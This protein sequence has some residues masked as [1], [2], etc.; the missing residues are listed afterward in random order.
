MKLIKSIIFALLLISVG[1]DVDYFDNPNQPTTPPSAAVFNNAMH[2]LITNTR[3]T[4][5]LGRFTQATMQYW[6]QSEY[7]DEDRYGYRESMRQTW[8]TFYYNLER[9]RIVIELN[10]DAATKDAMMA[11]GAN[12]NQ[13]ACARIM[14]AYTFNLMADTWGDIPYYSYGSPSANF[15]ALQLKDDVLNPRYATQAEIYADILNELQ[16]AADQLDSNLPGFTQGDVVYNGDVEKWRLFANSLRLR[17]AVK[18][19]SANAALATTHINDAIADGVFTSNDDNA[20]FTYDS[21]DKNA[22]PMYRAWNV[23]NR[24]DFAVSNTLVTLL[25]G[26]NIR[27]TPT[28]TDLTTNPFFGLYDPRLE[29]YA[30]RN[31]DGEYVGMPIAE[32]SAIAATITYESLPN[33]DNIIDKP[34]YAPVLMEYAEV[35]FLLSELNSWDQTNYTNGIRASMEKWG[36]PTADINAYIAAVPAANEENVLTQ[37]YIALYMDG[38]TAWAEYRR[39]GYPNILIKPGDDYT[40]YEPHDDVYYPFNFSAIPLEITNDLPTRMEYP[41]YEQ[42]LNAD[43]YFEA[44]DRLAT[45]DDLISPLWW[46]NN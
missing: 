13:I 35:E 32:S 24:S 5:F 44:V 27:E 23:D 22:S 28:G 7:G 20:V 31:S 42:T 12:V 36:V 17:I 29:Q 26:D 9:F 40:V 1:C 39:T 33:R 18:I 8:S 14:M 30:E 10:E 4:W 21:D 37:K 45:G 15:Q 41:G 2:S 19:Q 25:K 43:S 3:D 6:Q 34:D 38:A 16:E 11:Y 46:D